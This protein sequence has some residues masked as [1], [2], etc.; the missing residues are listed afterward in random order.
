MRRAP[1]VPDLSGT[2][3]PVNLL[4]NE[5]DGHESCCPRDNPV[6]LIQTIIIPKL[7]FPM[8]VCYDSRSG[9][10]GE[11]NT[12]ELRH[13]AFIVCLKEVSFRYSKKHVMCLLLK[14]VSFF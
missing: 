10:L 12:G 14:S 6:Q 13:H 2:L 3:L 8:L 1:V 11:G 7:L 4:G 9:P 5:D